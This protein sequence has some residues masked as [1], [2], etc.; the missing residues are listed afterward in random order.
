V[1]LPFLA[2]CAATAAIVVVFAGVSLADDTAGAGS[3]NNFSSMPQTVAKVVTNILR[4]LMII[5]GAVVAGKAMLGSHETG[6]HL[7]WYLVGAAFAIFAGANE[8][9]WAMATSMFGN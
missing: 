6:K 9:L 4:A 3:F 1:T 8:K 5:S 2:R 7:T